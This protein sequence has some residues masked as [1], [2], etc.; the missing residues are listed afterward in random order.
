M[1]RE[2]RLHGHDRLG[3]AYQYRVETATREAVSATVTATSVVVAARVARMSY[4]PNDPNVDTS[5][6]SNTADA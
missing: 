3:Q 6:Y 4:A 2:C 5:T 1:L